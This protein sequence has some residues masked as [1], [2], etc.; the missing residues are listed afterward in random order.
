M[1][2]TMKDVREI[3]TN[4]RIGLQEEEIAEL[5]DDLNEIIQSLKPITEFDLEGVEPTFHPI[6]GLSNIMREDEITPGLTHKEAMADAPSVQDGQYKIPPI[7]GDGGGD[8]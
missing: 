7:L 4:A 3:A 5:T 6:A 2:L 8:R 1:H